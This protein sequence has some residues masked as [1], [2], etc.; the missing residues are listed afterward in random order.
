LITQSL[1]HPKEKKCIQFEI[2]GEP[3]M[4][5][6]LDEDI[7]ILRDRQTREAIR[8]QSR[9][10]RKRNAGQ[11]LIKTSDCSNVLARDNSHDNIRQS[12]K[13]E[14]YP[15]GQ[16]NEVVSDHKDSGADNE[17]KANSWNLNK[18]PHVCTICE[19]SY[20]TRPGLSYHFIHIHNM[21]LPKNPQRRKVGTT[22]AGG[23]SNSKKSRPVSKFRQNPEKKTRVLRNSKL[24]DPPEAPESDD[25]RNSMTV[26]SKVLAECDSKEES[27]SDQTDI[28]STGSQE[29]DILSNNSDNCAESNGTHVTE[30]ENTDRSEHTIHSDGKALHPDAK[31]TAEVDACP[32]VKNETIRSDHGEIKKAHPN[33]FCDFCH[34]TSE[35]N[36]RTRLPERLI[37]CTSCGS[38]GHPTCLRFSENICLSIEKYD[39]QCTDCKTCSFCNK[40][41]NEGQLLF[42]DDCDRSY[43]T[44][45]LEPPLNEPP[46]GNWSCNLCLIEY[47][48]GQ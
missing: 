41:D 39:W 26:Q 42:C 7:Q 48:Q 38:S 36:R 12:E 23:E 4:P 15:D 27:L 5:N 47:H 35:R 2:D 44:Y 21:T 28:L 40:A 17:P 13:E 3:I 8:L 18:R 19:Q 9:M 30:M 10:S 11:S 6:C 14:G 29:T 22:R 25:P 33:H 1:K 45:C 32:K 31:H 16:F 24:E 20:K 46:E 34:G 37:S 43:H